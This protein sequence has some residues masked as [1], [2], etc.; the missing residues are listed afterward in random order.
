M[1]WFLNLFITKIRLLTID[2]SGERKVLNEM[3]K[4]EG[5]NEYLEMQRQAGFYL[6]AKTRNERHLGLVDFAETL[7][8]IFEEMNQ[9]A[10]VEPRETEGYESTN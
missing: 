1:K 10:E 5:I 6:F 3:R 9:P 8:R 7:M 2:E 4:I